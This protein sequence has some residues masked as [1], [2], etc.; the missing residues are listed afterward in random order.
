MSSSGLGSSSLRHSEASRYATY[1]AL[2]GQPTISVDGVD[3]R[4]HT[5]PGG[6]V[7]AKL[8]VRR[9]DRSIPLLRRVVRQE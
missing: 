4:L 6:L 1:S 3:L 2:T 7:E 9:A 5:P 8:H